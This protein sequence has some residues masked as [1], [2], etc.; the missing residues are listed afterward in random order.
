MP[1]KRARRRAPASLAALAG[2]SATRPASA[3]DIAALLDERLASQGVG[4]AAAQ[5]GG[6]DIEIAARG[7]LREDALLEIGSISKTFTALLLADAAVRGALKLDDSV[8]DVLAPLPL[9][10][11]AG[12]PIRWIDLATHRAGLPRLPPN[13]LPK[14]GADPYAGYGLADLEAFVRGFR[15]TVP[16]DARWEYSNLGYGLLGQALARAANTTFADLLGRRVLVPLDLR[17]VHLATPGRA[18]PRL[19]DGHDQHG[20]P[21]PHWRFDA[22]APAGAL[23]MPIATLARYAQAAIG[24]FDHPLREAFA[25]ALRE[26]RAGPS[27]ANPIGLA[28]LRGSLNGRIVHN[29]DGGTFGFASS[30]W[31][32]TSRRRAAVVVA[33][34]FVEVNDLALHL[35]DG[36]VPLKERR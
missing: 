16:R 36:T 35:L 11:S 31:L 26:H 1:S 27:P 13:L 12:A 3:R 19:A 10:D 9:R 15:P 30:L 32:D 22:L 18:A 21:V 20:R 4:L 8:E 34:A 2:G 29:H 28:W 25:L 23:L 5:V 7:R 24:D 33:N 17:E 14:D 6:S